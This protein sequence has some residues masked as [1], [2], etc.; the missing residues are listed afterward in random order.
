M[1]EHPAYSLNRSNVK[2]PLPVIA[3]A[4]L[5]LAVILGG[6]MYSLS[7]EAPATLDEGVGLGVAI[8][9]VAMT[10]SSL[11]FLCLIFSI[12]SICLNQWRAWS[13]AMAVLCLGWFVYIT[14]QI[15]T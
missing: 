1:S 15:A 14:W 6:F 8:M 12:L 3:T 4:F 13:S 9:A 7:L 10:V 2:N 5:L 11:A